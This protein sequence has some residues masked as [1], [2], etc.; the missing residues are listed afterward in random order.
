MP[1]DNLFSDDAFCDESLDDTSETLTGILDV[2]YEFG[3]D[4]TEMKKIGG[5]PDDADESM[6]SDD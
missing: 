6:D 3:T 2:D 4:D 5:D 1:G